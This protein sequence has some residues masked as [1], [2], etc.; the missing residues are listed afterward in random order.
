V[1]DASKLTGRFGRVTLGVT[2][3]AATGSGWRG[4]IDSRAM[5]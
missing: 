4:V 1:P 2:R 3:N 5:L